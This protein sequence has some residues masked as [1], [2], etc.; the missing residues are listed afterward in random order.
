MIKHKGYNYVFEATFESIDDIS[1][2][3][4]HPGH[5]D[6]AN[7]V[8]TVVEDYI[9]VNYKPMVFTIPGL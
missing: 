3:Y 5:T 8:A 4:D 1:N 9:V 7:E 6:F 2:Y